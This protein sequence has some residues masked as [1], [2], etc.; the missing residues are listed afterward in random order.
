MI[1]VTAAIIQR[2]GNILFAKRSSTSSLYGHIVM[3][4]RRH[5]D[6]I[7]KGMSDMGY[8]ILHVV[9]FLSYIIGDLIAILFSYVFS[10]KTEPTLERTSI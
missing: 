3:N 10:E 9:I 4:H 7:R 5:H 8:A 6:K 2:E 1:N